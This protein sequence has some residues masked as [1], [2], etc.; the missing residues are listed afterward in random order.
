MPLSEMS[1]ADAE[2]KCC[3]ESNRS[4]TCSSICARGCR[5]R[6]SPPSGEGSDA[7]DGSDIMPL[8]PISGP[9]STGFVRFQEVKW[10]AHNPNIHPRLC[11]NSLQ[12]T[13]GPADNL[14]DRPSKGN[15]Y[16]YRSGEALAGSCVVVADGALGEADA[17]SRLSVA[18]LRLSIVSTGCSDDR[19]DNAAFVT[20]PLLTASPPG[21]K[22][23][24]SLIQ[25]QSHAVRPL[26]PGAGRTRA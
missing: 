1:S 2:R 18:M 9:V 23:A 19:S 12:G 20:S 21:A 6:S 22:H 10:R 17:S 16:P 7:S 13:I 8:C 26:R 4:S 5:R 14:E 15:D 24:M 25:C 3:T 11:K